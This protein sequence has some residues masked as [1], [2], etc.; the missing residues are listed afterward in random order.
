[1]AVPQSIQSIYKDIFRSAG[2]TSKLMEL[3]EAERLKEI[4]DEKETELVGVNDVNGS[5]ESYQSD[6]I[7][8]GN[9]SIVTQAD[10]DD[11]KAEIDALDPAAT[12]YA[13]EKATLEAELNALE[14]ALTS[15][16]NAPPSDAD[17][18]DALLQN[19]IQIYDPLV[20]Y[21]GPEAP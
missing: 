19:G 21:D 16:S 17:L 15:T 6:A 5:F 8:E 3:E 12:D 13:T 14:T 7:W 10:V 11:V 1:M 18:N 2:Y 4:Q 9:R 20:G